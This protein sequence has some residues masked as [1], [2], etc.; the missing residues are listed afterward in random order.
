MSDPLSPLRLNVGFIVASSAGYSR[1]FVFDVP[2]IQLP[3]DLNLNDLTGTTL[4]SRTP[5]G[6]LIQTDLRAVL[7]LECVLCLNPIHH[8]LHT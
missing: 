6:I 3:P 5:Q 8:T 2:R 4:I 1:E 7:N